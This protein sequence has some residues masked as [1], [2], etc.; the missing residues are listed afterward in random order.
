[1]LAA[2]CPQGV[3]PSTGAYFWT[4]GGVNGGRLGRVLATLVDLVLPARCVGCGRAGAVLCPGCGPVGVPVGLVDVRAGPGGELAVRAAAP[5]DGPIRTA[6]I[7]YKERGR[8]DLARP[9]GGLLAT[10]LP[11]TAAGAWLVPVPSTRAARRARGGDHVARLARIAGRVST[12][13]SGRVRVRA[14]LR[15]VR[16]VEDSAGLDAASREAN[17]RRAMRAAP[18]P[19]SSSS[20]VLVDDIVTTGATLSEAARALVAAGWHVECAAVV[21]AT[22]R[23]ARVSRPMPPPHAGPSARLA[24]RTG[25]V[26]REMT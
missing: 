13:Q 1:V 21:A 14:P 15:W 10:A 4:H 16:A 25:R 18:P 12:Q 26:Y 19:G 6:L 17:V 9:L 11:I 5:Y 8:R 3:A 20:A 2:G 23:R 7:A 24:G 22:P